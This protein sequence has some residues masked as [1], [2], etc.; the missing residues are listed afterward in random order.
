MGLRVDARAQDL[1][2]EHF[3][4]LYCTLHKQQQDQQRQEQ[5]AALRLLEQGGVGGGDV[6]ASY[7]SS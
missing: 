6:P 5:E 2:F 4:E 1:T 3:V 7:S